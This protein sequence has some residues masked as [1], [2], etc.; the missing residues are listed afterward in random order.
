M[1]VQLD[2]EEQDESDVKTKNKSLAIVNDKHGDELETS[3]KE[4]TEEA[5][6]IESEATKIISKETTDANCWCSR[7]IL[8][9]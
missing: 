2:E 8:F 3:Q 4:E 5:V 1:E 7:G 6:D 9:S